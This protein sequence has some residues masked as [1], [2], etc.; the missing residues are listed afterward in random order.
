VRRRPWRTRRRPRAASRTTMCAAMFIAFQAT[1][2]PVAGER[3]NHLAS[4]SRSRTQ[5]SVGGTLT[6]N[7][8]PSNIIQTWLS[9]DSFKSQRP[10]RQQGGLLRSDRRRRHRACARTGEVEPEGRESALG[11]DRSRD[12]RPRTLAAD[13]EPQHGRLPLGARRH[14][15]VPPAVGHA[16]RPAVGAVEGTSSGEPGWGK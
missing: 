6:D 10:Q 15:P 14:L 7:P 9:C 12:R 16:A 1:A 2:R 3:Y 5:I 4:N 8:A 11:T 13:P